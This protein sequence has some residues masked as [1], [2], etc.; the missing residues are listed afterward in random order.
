MVAGGISDLLGLATTHAAFHR[1][2]PSPLG[3]HHRIRRLG[4]IPAPVYLGSR[5]R[6][7]ALQV[8]VRCK[9]M[10]VLPCGS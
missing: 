3:I 7:R 2:C 9:P 10:H 1:S 6:P 5:R 8:R 4:L